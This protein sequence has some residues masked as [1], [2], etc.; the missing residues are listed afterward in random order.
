MDL[1]AQDKEDEKDDDAQ[2]PEQPGTKTTVEI[3]LIIK[4]E[5]SVREDRRYAKSIASV[6]QVENGYLI[7]PESLTLPEKEWP[8]FEGTNR[9]QVL[10]P[11]TLT[12]ASQRWQAKMSTKRRQ[13]YGK[14]NRH[15]V[16]G[17]SCRCW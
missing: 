13:I 9:S 2:Q 5:K 4:Q 12:P 16:G 14:S 7:F 8:D 3:V 6:P 10:G 1:D 15:D 11:L 17:P